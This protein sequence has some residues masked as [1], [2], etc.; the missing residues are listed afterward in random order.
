MLTEQA[1]QERLDAEEARWAEVGKQLQRQYDM[2][3]AAYLGRVALLKELLAPPVP[4][5]AP[6]DKGAGDDVTAGQ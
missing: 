4:E 2:E 6:D 5:D 1:I 3:H